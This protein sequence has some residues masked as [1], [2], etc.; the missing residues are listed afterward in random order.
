MIDGEFWLLIFKILL[1]LP[2][3]I[4]IL[5]LS[6]RFGGSK[7]QKLQDG[8]YMKI[9]DRISL[10]KENS[11]VVVKIGEKAYAIS[12]SS[13]EIQILFEIPKEEIVS[14]EN[15]KDIPQFEDMKDLFKKHIMK[16]EGKDEKKK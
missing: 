3:I 7:L 10:S 9:L 5:Y 12:S 6:L 11:V 13:K 16:K 15:N 14:I 8:K 1:F 2:F 4:F